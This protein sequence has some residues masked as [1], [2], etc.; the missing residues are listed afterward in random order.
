M[1]NLK[2][3]ANFF[4]LVSRK[5]NRIYNIIYNIKMKKE[6]GNIFYRSYIKHKFHL[7]L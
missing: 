4:K 5:L 3:S 7:N 1:L 6:F 2:D